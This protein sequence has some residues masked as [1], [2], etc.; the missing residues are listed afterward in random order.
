MN[1]AFTTL[2]G[3]LFMTQLIFG[4][5]REGTDYNTIAESK[6]SLGFKV[7][8]SFALGDFGEIDVNNEKA[9]LA[10]TG[11]HLNA[12][13]SYLIT[14]SFYF[15]VE[16]G[17]SSNPIDEDE[18][19]IPIQNSVQNSYSVSATSKSWN[20][21]TFNVGVGTRTA[22]DA[23]T[24]FLTKFGLGLHNM[25]SPN[26]TITISNGQ[27]TQLINQSS[28]T[29][30]TLNLNLGAAIMTEINQTTYFTIGLDYLRAVHDFEDIAVSS[31]VN[32]TSAGPTEFADY[33]QSVETISI[34]IGINIKI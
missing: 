28:S 25:E 21:K 20:A 12:N 6:L 30:N 16:A 2:F 3:L 9:G 15:I 4:Q 13:L 26:I 24:Y 32:G 34:T 5:S 7:G 8:P 22:I 29:S 31:T 10:K 17:Y 33:S 27:V 1:K 14:S 18:L 11:I 23:Q 19:I